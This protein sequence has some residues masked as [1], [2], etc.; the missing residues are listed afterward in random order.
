[1]HAAADVHNGIEVA[2]GS[3]SRGRMVELLL[4][5]SANVHAR[6]DSR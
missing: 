5:H 3:G 1:M 4:F 2:R 6:L